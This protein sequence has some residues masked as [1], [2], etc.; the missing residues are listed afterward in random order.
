MSD[1]GIKLIDSNEFH[2]NNKAEIKFQSK[3]FWE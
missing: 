3:K 2:I 1:S